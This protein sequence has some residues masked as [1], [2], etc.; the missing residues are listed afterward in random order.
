MMNKM[1]YGFDYVCVWQTLL[2][3]IYLISPLKQL[4]IQLFFLYAHTLK[5]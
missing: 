1:D 2:E 4:K 5:T 3:S